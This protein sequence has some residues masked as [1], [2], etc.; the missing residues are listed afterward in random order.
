MKVYLFNN[1]IITDEGIYRLKK[2]SIQEFRKIWEVAFI[3]VSAIGHEATAQIFSKI[4]GEKVEVN[5]VQAIQK[6]GEIALVLKM[7]GRI[8]EGSRKRHRF[9]RRHPKSPLAIR[10]EQACRNDQ[11]E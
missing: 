8:K 6:L 4:L 5:R 11:L 7:K 9:L 1:S 3:K 2:S 10:V